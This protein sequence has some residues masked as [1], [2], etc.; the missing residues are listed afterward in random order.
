MYV[1]GFA[2]GLAGDPNGKD[3]ESLIAQE[4]RLLRYTNLIRLSMAGN[5]KDF[6]VVPG[7][8]RTTPGK[9]LDYN[10]KGAGYTNDPQ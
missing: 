5:L 1:Q 3:P 9:K 10:V 8:G 6:G 2:T 4:N 7:N